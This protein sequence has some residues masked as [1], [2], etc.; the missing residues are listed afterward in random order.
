MKS[1][2]KD[3]AATAITTDLRVSQ[4]NEIH[5]LIQADLTTLHNGVVSLGQLLS[6][7]SESSQII[8]QDHL[9]NI[10]ELFTLMANQ[11]KALHLLDDLAEYTLAQGSM[12]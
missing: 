2:L 9:G 12:E 11:I 1:L 7:A 3:L 6:L 4:L 10:G 5:D 8:G